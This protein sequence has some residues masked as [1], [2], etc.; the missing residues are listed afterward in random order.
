MMTESLRTDSPG[1][2]ES[3]GYTNQQAWDHLPPCTAGMQ[4]AYKI[5]NVP[6]NHS[7]LRLCSIAM[8]H[9][10]KKYTLCLQGTQSSSSFWLEGTPSY[11]LASLFSMIS[12]ITSSTPLSSRHLQNAQYRCSRL[13]STGPSP[14]CRMCFESQ[15]LP[16]TLDC[17]NL[18]LYS[19]HVN[20]GGKV[21]FIYSR[22]PLIKGYGKHARLL[23]D[24][25]I[26]GTE[27]LE[28]HWM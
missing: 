24:S 27:L 22:D 15:G 8:Q 21:C 20:Q 16:V 14:F 5:M 2:S 23:N 28:A 7:N 17:M 25:F 9:Q 10:L 6:S 12:L 3:S 4:H 18:D 26:T 1:A 13:H 19:E 11:P